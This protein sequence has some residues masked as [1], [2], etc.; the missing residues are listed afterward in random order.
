MR[1]TREEELRRQWLEQA[2]HHVFDITNDQ[3][4]RFFTDS[5]KER[6]GLTLRELWKQLPK[7][8]SEDLDRLPNGGEQFLFYG[9]PGSN[10]RFSC[11]LDFVTNPAQACLLKSLLIREPVYRHWL[12]DLVSHVGNIDLPLLSEEQ[13]SALRTCSNCSTRISSGKVLLCLAPYI[14]QPYYECG[15]MERCEHTG[16]WN[17]D[18]KQLARS[19]SQPRLCMTCSETQSNHTGCCLKIGDSWS[20]CCSRF[21]TVPFDVYNAVLALMSQDI[22]EMPTLNV[23]ET[24]N[25][26]FPSPNEDGADLPFYILTNT[27]QP[28]ASPTL[29]HLTRYARIHLLAQ[30]IQLA[31]KQQTLT[32]FVEEKV[33]YYAKEIHEKEYTAKVKD[34]LS[35]TLP[36]VK[37][38]QSQSISSKE[39]LNY[40]E[41]VIAMVLKQIADPL[42]RTVK[43][44][45]AENEAWRSF[46]RQCI[47]SNSIDRFTIHTELMPYIHQSTTYLDQKLDQL[48]SKVESRPVVSLPFPSSHRKMPVSQSQRSPIV[49]LPQQALCIPESSASDEAQHCGLHIPSSDYS[50]ADAPHI[51]NTQISPPSYQPID[52]FLDVKNRWKLFSL[53]PASVPVIAAQWGI[54]PKHMCKAHICPVCNLF[55]ETTPNGEAM[56]LFLGMD[57]KSIMHIFARKPHRGPSCPFFFLLKHEVGEQ[58]AVLFRTFLSYPSVDKPLMRQTIGFKTLI[59][60]LIDHPINSLDDKSR[61][62]GFFANKGIT[63]E[64]NNMQLEVIQIKHFWEGEETPKPVA[65]EVSKPLPQ[66]TVAPFAA[67]HAMLRNK[68]RKQMD[69]VTPRKTSKAK[70]QK[71][72]DL[73]DPLPGEDYELV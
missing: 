53:N 17:H 69:A 30:V 61:F 34:A 18:P 40:T 37:L 49:A 24:S 60:W 11:L 63:C 8:S 47:E 55:T 2:K 9:F 38:S 46:G 51:P 41:N 56:Y 42:V 54:N 1:R 29:E 73:G 4:D 32:P 33:A 6:L 35:M 68:K 67:F 25:P 15:R 14:M 23:K 62:T 20:S 27:P 36:S 57:Q 19:L 45:I 12:L 48:S 59:Q 44:L 58:E 16:A 71:L 22:R 72:E 50:A 64:T 10:W 26:V 21:I 5:E 65:G 39:S 28:G 31:T 66:P 3:I 70:R 13:V 43:D 7:V 52:G